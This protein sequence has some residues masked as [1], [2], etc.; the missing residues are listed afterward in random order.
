MIKT[1]LIIAAGA[2]SRLQQVTGAAPKP[3][4]RLAGVPLIKRIILTARKA[5][6][7]RFVVVTGYAADQIR[8]TLD[9][10]P[11][12]VGLI[13]WVHNDQWELP[14][15][16]SVL[17]ARPLLAE[18]FILMM[19]DHLFEEKTLKSMIDLP[20]AAGECV[21][22]VDRNTDKIYDIDDATKVR[23]EG[24][25]LTEIGKDLN[26][27]NAIDTGMFACTPV[28][29]DALESCR[30]EKGCSL[31]DGIRTL[32]RQGRMRVLDI[33]DGFWQDVDTPDMVAHAERTLLRRLRKPTDGWVSRY[34]NRPISTRIS[35]LL[36][37]TPITPNQVT[38]VT[39]ATG[40]VSAYMIAEGSYQATLLGALLFQLSSVLDGCDG[41][42]AK[43]TFRESR[44][45]SWLDTV[46]D[47]LTYLAFFLGVLW[48][49]GN[50]DPSPRIWL[51]GGGSLAAVAVSILLMYYYLA[52]T[53][54]GG[55]LVRYNE[56]FR[57][58]KSRPSL[59]SRVLDIL[60]M[61]SKRDFFTML[62]LCFA[63][64]GRLDW[65]F[66]TITGGGFATAIAVFVSTGRLIARDRAASSPVAMKT[67]TQG[68]PAG[69]V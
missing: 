39:F 55:S 32:S 61:M 36:V 67:Q 28:L 60:R 45:G 63:A 31:S 47:N 58:K 56:A 15:G 10:D 41:E 24:D 12:L 66:W 8:N 57:A 27:Y 42:V 46:T 13:E 65:M 40:L 7:E 26:E 48:G 11:Q 17:S 6:I 53:G 25:R 3:L 18:P 35:R 51:L 37:R 68:E 5:G 69:S 4:L 2:G 49:Y 34:L 62:F 14:N 23:A 30:T 33:G 50:T 52:A 54:E 16:V 20:V 64:A 38:L 44:Y 22:A 59:M 43:L 29:F 9:T 1:A 21:L 19:S